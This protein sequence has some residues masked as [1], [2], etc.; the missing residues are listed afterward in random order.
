MINIVP[1][2]DLKEHIDSSVCKCCPTVEFSNGEM[3]IIHNSYDGREFK[4]ELINNI[5]EN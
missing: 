1:V 4:E 5:G 3:I 2:N